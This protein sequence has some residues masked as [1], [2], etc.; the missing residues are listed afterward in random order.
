MKVLLTGSNGFIGL[1]TIRELLNR[2]HHVLALSRSNAG[3]QKILSNYPSSDKDI[4]IIHGSTDNYTLMTSTAA[5]SD[6]VIHL[7]YNHDFVGIDRTTAA[8]QDDAVLDALITGLDQDGSRTEK[9]LIVAGGCGS[10]RPA[11]LLKAGHATLDPLTEDDDFDKSNARTQSNE[12][13]VHAEGV[14]GI[15]MRLA[16]TVHGKGDPN[17]VTLVQQAIVKNKRAVYLGPGTNRWPACHVNDTAVALVLALERGRRGYLHLIA[18]EGVAFKDIVRVLGEQIGL[19]AESVGQEEFRE[20]Y[21]WLDRVLTQDRPTNGRKT[22]E[23]LGWTPREIG[24][25]EDIRENY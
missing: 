11:H 25:L 18:E 20:F 21:G 16:P 10:L 14:R 17:F 8:K 24:L 13:V 6:G 2:G 4:T 7:A 1:P 12:K 15:V 5:D 9:P 22:Q 19:Q 23:M 3:A